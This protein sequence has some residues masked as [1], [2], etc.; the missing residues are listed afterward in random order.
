MQFQPVARDG[1]KTVRCSG[2]LFH[3]FSPRCGATFFFIR[4]ISTFVCDMV[5]QALLL[6]PVFLGPICHQPIVC[7]SRPSQMTAVQQG[8][9]Q[10]H[11]HSSS[12]SEHNP[13][14]AWQHFI[15]LHICSDKYI[16]LLTV[17]FQTWEI[18][19]KSRIDEFCS[20]S[21][22]ALEKPKNPRTLESKNLDLQSH[23]LSR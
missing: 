19:S 23:H 3:M 22:Y 10:V 18:F 6:A 20:P 2:L 13:F 11:L 15:V 9:F 4:S 7:H 5:N 17:L 21:R 1:R 12:E 14:D 8:I 16:W